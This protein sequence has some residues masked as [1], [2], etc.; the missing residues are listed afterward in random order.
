VALE[1]LLAELDRREQNPDWRYDLEETPEDRA[2]AELIDDG[3]DEFDAYAQVYG[4]DPEMMRREESRAHVESQRLSGETLDQVVR[5]LF[6]EW[7]EL[8]FIAAE[9]Y[10]RGVLV[11]AE[12]R[13][14]GIDG[15]SLL[16]GRQDVAYKWASDELKT[17]WEKHP[18][19]TLVEFRAQMLGRASDKQA[20]KLIKESRR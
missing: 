19:M 11:N 5:R 17:W 18:R 16:S 13:R 2:V 10:T 8:Q 7:L 3:V 14:R 12:G 20:A 9:R 4:L 1:R 6:E 15:R